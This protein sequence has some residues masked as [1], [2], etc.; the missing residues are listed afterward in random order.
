MR[1][2]RRDASIEVWKGDELLE[3]TAGLVIRDR[4]GRHWLLEGRGIS[5][6]VT[7]HSDCG[8]MEARP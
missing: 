6:P 2:F 4:G 1:L 5:E 3:S 8:C 7:H